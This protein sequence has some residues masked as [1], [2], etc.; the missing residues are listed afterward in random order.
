MTTTTLDPPDFARCQGMHTTGSPLA[1][2]N[3]VR[4][5]RCKNK[6]VVLASENAPGEDGMQGAMTLCNDCLAVF[7]KQM[8]AGVATFKVI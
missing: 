6:P 2:A 5:V 1:I 8:P 7:Q 3:P 4:W